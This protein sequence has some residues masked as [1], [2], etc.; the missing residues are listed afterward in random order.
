MVFLQYLLGLRALGHDAW[1]LELLSSSG[2]DDC[3]R[4]L[5]ETFFE[6]MGRYEFREQ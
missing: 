3:D 2:D 5:I 1:W 6:R 4:R